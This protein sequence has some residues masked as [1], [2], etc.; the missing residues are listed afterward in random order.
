MTTDE[1]FD[2]CYECSGLGD[3]YY[4]DEDGDLV[5]FCPECPLNPGR[6]DDD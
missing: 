3:D 5:C 1:D 2:Y 4:V 6:R